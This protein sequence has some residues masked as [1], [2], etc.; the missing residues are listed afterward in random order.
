KSTLHRHVERLTSELK[1]P[2]QELA[3]L[4]REEA[5][6]RYRVFK[7][8]AWPLLSATEQSMWG[9]LF[10]MQHY[11]LPTRLL[12][13]TE[14]FMCALFFAQQHRE[15]GDVAAVW[16]LDSAAVNEISLGESGVISLDETAE[17]AKGDARAWHPRWEPPDQEL[18]TIAGAPIFT[19][20]R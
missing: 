2:P 5:K 10:A 14:S 7:Q 4:F 13:W 17:E 9:V 8:E 19:T 16:A 18:P 15:P 11:R 3:K 6:T 1:L 20:P 12:D